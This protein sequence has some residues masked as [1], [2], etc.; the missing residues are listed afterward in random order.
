MKT[1]TEI[2]AEVDRRA[3]MIGAAGHQSLPTYGHTEDFARPNVE[4]DSRGYHLVVVERGQQQ[5]R[6]TTCDL[7]DLLFQIFQSVT[8]TLAV[9]YELEHRIGTQDC[10]RIAF[11]RQVELLSQLSEF[12]GRRE[13]KEH[14]HILREHPFD[15]QSALRAQ[16]SAQVGWGKACEQYPL[17]K[18]PDEPNRNTQDFAAVG[19][20]IKCP[21][22]KHK[23]EF[24]DNFP[25]H[26]IFKCRI[27]TQ[28]KF[29]DL[30][31]GKETYE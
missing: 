9:G 20:L 7:D 17:P 27:C 25:G 2:K 22:D 16:L 12:W 6:F 11:R 24:F 13:A 23:W 10:R 21:P 1:I 26:E 28:K 31:T 3:A 19:A 4:V 8:S 15:D 29:V 18:T 30:K 5:S 14:E